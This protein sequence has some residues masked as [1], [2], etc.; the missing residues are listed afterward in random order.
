M[1]SS[2]SLIMAVWL[3]VSFLCISGVDMLKESN[4]AEASHILLNLLCRQIKTVLYSRTSNKGW[5][6]LNVWVSWS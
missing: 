5:Q 6:L 4:L 2:S 1:F 3:R